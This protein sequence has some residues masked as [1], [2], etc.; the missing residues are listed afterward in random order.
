MFSQSW[1]DLYC[2]SNAPLPTYAPHGA[3]R[4]INRSSASVTPCGPSKGTLK[5]MSLAHC[6]LSR[7]GGCGDDGKCGIHMCGD[8]GSG[9]VDDPASPLSP[10]LPLSRHG[11]KPDPLSMMRSPLTGIGGNDA[12]RKSRAR[13]SK[14]PIPITPSR[15]AIYDGND[16]EVESVLGRGAFGLVLLVRPTTRQDAPGLLAM[17]T[18]DRF[19]LSTPSLRKAVEREI[20]IMRELPSHC[21][22]VPLVDVIQTQRSFHMVFEY[23]AG[24]TLQDFCN[25]HGALREASARALTQQLCEAVAHLHAHRICHR[26]LKLDNMVLDGAADEE[27]DGEGCCGSHLTRVRIIDFGLSAVIPE[28]APDEVDGSNLLKKVA[29]SLA[30]M[31]PE[32]IARRPYRGELVDA[33]SLGVCVA[34]MLI[35]ALPFTA[36]SD[37]ELRA[38]IA[39]GHYSLAAR[40]SAGDLD[41]SDNEHEH[42][43]G[44]SGRMNGRHEGRPH[45]G[46]AEPAA[47]ACAF[48]A[49]LLTKDPNERSSVA[50]AC[51]HAW[52]RAP[53][54]NA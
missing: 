7:G 16:Y 9:D 24:G 22:I 52:L 2:T 32:M 10:L 53:P 46:D 5:L 6:I 25:E 49:S 11:Q 42:Q 3:S 13:R 40:D 4:A 28:D 29:G 48:V 44:R 19:R 50:A 39:S 31:A 30:Y 17:K 18:V 36:S 26:D 33:W 27:A 54:S 38:V 12:S 14:N 23:A 47:A 20:K 34:A 51:K 21:G 8:D 41:E 1:A 15:Y 35:G 37:E 43:L 45:S